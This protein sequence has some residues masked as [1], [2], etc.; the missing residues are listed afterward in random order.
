M[1]ATNFAIEWTGTD[2]EQGFRRLANE[3]E[4]EYGWDSYNGTISTTRLSR[5]RPH[6]I[7][8]RYTKTADKRAEAYLE[9]VDYGRKWE[10]QV[11]DLGI[12]GYEIS[13]F[14]KVPHT[15]ADAQFQTRYVAYADSYEIGTYKTAAEARAAL[16]DAIARPRYSKTRYFH[17][18]KKSVKVAGKSTTTCAYERQTRVTKTKPKTTP[19]GA[20]VTPI[21]KFVFYGWASC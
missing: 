1:G 8:D 17:A 21:H 13:K 11:L 10:T 16:E 5:T 19:K 20:T 15:K 14:V 2:Y 18:E 4:R 12:T 6:K 3:A 9:K 7:A